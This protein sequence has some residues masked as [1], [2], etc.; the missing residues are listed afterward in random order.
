MPREAVA[1]R[2]SGSNGAAAR[3]VQL[4]MSISLVRWR[5]AATVTCRAGVITSDKHTRL[6]QSDTLDAQ[7]KMKMQSQSLSVLFKRVDCQRARR[8]ARQ[9]YR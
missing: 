9:R 1:E 7:K 3:D 8:V 6:I 5:L 4:F 2:F